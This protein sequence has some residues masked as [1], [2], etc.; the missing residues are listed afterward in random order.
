MSFDADVTACAAI[1][2]KGDPERFA[3]VMASPVAAR[4]V[5]IPVETGYFSLHGLSKQLETLNIL[6]N[7]CQQKVDVKVLVCV[8]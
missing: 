2:E 4:E 6:C 1:V 7:R 8:G 3:A 5:L